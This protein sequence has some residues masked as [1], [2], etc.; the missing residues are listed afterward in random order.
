MSPK[1]LGPAAPGSAASPEDSFGDDASKYS[2]NPRTFQE[3]SD[4]ERAGIVAALS[5]RGGTAR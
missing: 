4:G 5:F 1:E 2:Q 3:L